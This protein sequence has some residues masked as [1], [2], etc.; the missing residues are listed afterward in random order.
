MAEELSFRNV[1]KVWRE[2][3]IPSNH[4]THHRISRRQA[5]LGHRMPE[6]GPCPHVTLGTGP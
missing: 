3:L 1:F 4:S 6:L 5:E 2:A